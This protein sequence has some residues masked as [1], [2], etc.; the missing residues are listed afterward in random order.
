MW[1]DPATYSD[2]PAMIGIFGLLPPTLGANRTIVENTA[3]KIAEI[4]ESGDL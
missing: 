1:A 3:D 4:W 2:H